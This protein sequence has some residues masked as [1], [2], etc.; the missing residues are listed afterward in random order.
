MLDAST[1]LYGVIGNPV[2]HSLSPII[3]NVSFKRAGINAVYLAF[4]INNLSDALKGI[5][6]LGIRG[7]SVTIPFK[8]EVVKYLDEIDPIAKKIKAV[9]TILNHEGNLLG[10]NTDW[11]GALEAL[12][13]VTD[14][15]EKKI[16][17]LGAGGASRAIVYG[18]SRAG[19]QVIITNRSIDRAKELAE[20]FGCLYLKEPTSEV[21]IIINSTPVGMYPLE[22]E[23]PLPKHYLRKGMIVMDTVYKPLKT[24]LLREAEERG[25]LTINGLSMLSYQGAYQFEIWTGTKPDILKIKE[26]LINVLERG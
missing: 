8:T 13:E 16:L 23:T 17:V 18:L 14:L 2:R 15:D 11:L 1:S 25:C 3:H 12:K 9:N 10:F 20:E 5:K 21:D 19:C 24:R 26:D 7:L 4:E 22:N 6:A